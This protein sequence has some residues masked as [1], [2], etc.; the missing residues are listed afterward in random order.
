MLYIITIALHFQCKSLNIILPH[1]SLPGEVY[2]HMCTHQH[3]SK[4]IYAYKNLYVQI[5]ITNT[6]LYTQKL[7][8]Q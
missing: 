1:E 5:S 8:S 3:M 4:S 7:L 2:N 6:A